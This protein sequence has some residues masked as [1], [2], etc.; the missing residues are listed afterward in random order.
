ME[1]LTGKQLGQYRLVARL[2]AGGMASVYKA[3]QPS[4][5]RYV[6]LKI[7]PR[8]YAED[9]QF[10][11]RFQREARIIASLE[12]PHI[13]PIYDFGQQDGYTF[14]VMRLVE[15][16]SLADM[17]PLPGH[18]PL[19]LPEIVKYIAQVAAAL[20]YAHL[21]Q[22]L[23]RD[24]KP[25]NV[26][27]DALGNCLLTD[28]GIA[29]ILTGNTQ[30]TAS[31]AFL[32]TPAYASPEQC[33]GKPDIDHRSDIY[34]L[35]V[36]LY[37]MATGRLPFTAET[38][39]AV[40]MKHIHDPLP[41]PRQVNPA[42]PEA[43]EGV[44]LKAMSK[45]PNERYASA[46]QLASALS[47][48]VE[49]PQ[50]PTP[51]PAPQDQTGETTL[52]PAPVELPPMLPKAA[53]PGLTWKLIAALAVLFGVLGMALAG[54]RLVTALTKPGV[55]PTASLSLPEL[56]LEP[57][58]TPE[59]SDM[60]KL[61]KPSPA[62]SAA[63]SGAGIPSATPPNPAL[64]GTAVPILRPDLTEL[65]FS[66]RPRL[67]SVSDKTYLTWA[68]NSTGVWR[69]Y[70]SVKP[71]GGKFSVP[72]PLP[73]SS[74]AQV[75]PC[76]AVTSAGRLVL[77][78]QQSVA[79]GWQIFSAYSD[80]GKQFSTPIQVST[81]SD[82]QLPAIT[83]SE[84]GDGQIFLAWQGVQNGDWDIYLASSTDGGESFSA[85]KRVNTDPAGQQVSP[86]IAADPLGRITLA[87]S[88]DPSGSWRIWFTHAQSIYDD[89]PS[90]RIAA[91]GLMED[92]ADQLPSLAVDQNYDVHLAWSNAYVLHPDYQAPLYLPAN[93]YFTE[94]SYQVSE[95][96]Q[97]GSG[98]KHVSTRQTEISNHAV[99]SL[100]H[101]V[102][103][104]YSPRDGSF[105]WYYR[106][107][108]HG[109]TFTEPVAVA[110]SPKADDL[111]D[112]VVAS[113][114]AYEI[115]VAWAHQ[116]GE[117]WEVQISASADG[118]TFSTIQTIAGQP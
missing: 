53:R 45:N 30:L 55:A 4:T 93:A 79:A 54:Y 39:M 49:A 64:N 34:S 72:L 59:A 87:W 108:D 48:A 2:G 95:T 116:R 70:L 117:Q 20:D 105:V 78:W 114:G 115:I 18:K 1:D 29:R 65:P 6:A 91:S 81:G 104:T 76:L 96:N 57:T 110:S 9:L 46:V 106:S 56:Y 86:A 51:I 85:P 33:L 37:E 31:G 47:E 66:S 83:Y 50:I 25:S 84:V 40:V 11:Q 19:P 73:A 14:L 113:G 15:G 112:P 94:A 23:H 100:I 60:Q 77:A 5:D 62:T 12:H 42:L 17:V 21:H 103:T 97:V 89:F 92:L 75:A 109:Q 68:D 90:E 52:G 27:V 102:L 101:V 32:G 74:E 38:P 10:I 111:H 61:E 7:L 67:L 82:H 63:V 107:D 3:Y 99:D 118:A 26:L 41:P 16:R 58:S 28:F 13:L 69:A 22:V 8:S 44:I 24:I 80:D 36:M 35:G 71:Q 43:V 88:G 98:Y